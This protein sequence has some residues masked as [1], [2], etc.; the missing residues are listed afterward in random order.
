MF[1]YMTG[2]LSYRQVCGVMWYDNLVV[3]VVVF[4][5]NCNIYY[6]YFLINILNCHCGVFCNLKY[7]ECP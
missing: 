7:D 4:H 2:N 6:D 1:Y 5:I 3:V